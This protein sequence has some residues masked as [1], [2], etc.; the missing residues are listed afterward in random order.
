MKVVYE[1]ELV[2]KVRTSALPSNS[3][4]DPTTG[5]LT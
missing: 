5:Q 4:T 2:I 3:Q 1:K